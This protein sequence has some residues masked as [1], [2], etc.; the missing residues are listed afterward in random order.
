M[1]NDQQIF[2]RV[3][4]IQDTNAYGAVHGGVILEALVDGAIDWA[5][6]I[7]PDSRLSHIEQT[8]FHQPVQAALNDKMTV[9]CDTTEKTADN[10][11]VFAQ[12]L[13]TQPGKDK[14]SVYASA[15]VRFTIVK[16]W[17]QA[18]PRTE[19]FSHFADIK[20]TIQNTDQKVQLK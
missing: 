15:Q 7:S 20:A 3:L 4:T 10:L 12:L 9:N 6:K 5:K 1:T 18:L 8:V 19:P 17:S 13:T 14:N 2:C 11:L 16:R